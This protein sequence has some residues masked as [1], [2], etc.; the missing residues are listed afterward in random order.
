M[1]V[2]HFPRDLRLIN[3]KQYSRVFEKANKIHNKAFTLLARKNE[4]NHARLGLVIA[5][6]NVKFAYQRNFIKRQLREYFRRHLKTFGNY[7]LVLLTRRDIASL[8]KKDI[9]NNRNKLF[10]RFNQQ[11]AK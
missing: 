1:P 5:K 4:L 3:A 6:K 10:Q 7:D 9:I 2:E 11:T 8:S